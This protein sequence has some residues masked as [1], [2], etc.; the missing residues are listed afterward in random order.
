MDITTVILD[1]AG[2]TVDFGCL[3]P[4]SAFKTAFETFGLTPTIEET[5][6]PMGLSKRRHIEAMLSGNRLRAAFKWRFGREW[7]QEDADQIYH[8]FEPALFAVLHE[9][10]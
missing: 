1:W 2:T 3:A 10:L 5:R 4:V 9:S 6:A 7:T 8:D